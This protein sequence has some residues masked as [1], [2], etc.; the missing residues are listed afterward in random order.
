MP[1]YC[2][3]WLSIG[4]VFLALKIVVLLRTDSATR[5]QLPWPR[6]LGFLFFWPGMRLRPFLVTAEAP[7]E[8]KLQPGQLLASGLINLLCGVATLYAANN[9]PPIAN[10]PLPRAAMALTG[11]G[12]V[13]LFGLFDL[14]AAF[15]QWRGV[16][17]EKQ[18]NMPIA[19]R[20]LAEYWSHRWN[21]AF[22]DF[23]R[24]QIFRPLHGWLGPG[25][26][27][28]LSFLFSGAL[29][30]V[31]I[32][33]PAR[34]G[35][36]LPTVYFLIQAIGIWIERRWLVHRPQAVKRLWALVVVLGPLGLLF[37]GPFIRNIILPQLDALPGG[38]AENSFTSIVGLPTSFVASGGGVGDDFNVD[39][40]LPFN[41]L[42]FR[43][44]FGNQIGGR[45]IFVGI[46]ASRGGLKADFVLAD[47]RAVLVAVGAEHKI[48]VLIEFGHGCPA[49]I[50]SALA[51]F[52]HHRREHDHS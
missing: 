22:H 1:S 50:H 11:L 41:H 7:V 35:Y 6:L 34:G 38:G 42:D 14:L 17:V 16:H 28:V 39:L 18:W 47:H 43:L 4:L 5:R 9:V 46:I 33:V 8:R 40:V 25:Q 29:H 44:L 51:P 2:W 48:A 10:H 26:A 45:A 24:E 15:W 12:L 3:T 52:L 21:R 27:L 30:D 19:S 36:G 31:G 20:S 49:G 23:A 32:S 13:L 37:H